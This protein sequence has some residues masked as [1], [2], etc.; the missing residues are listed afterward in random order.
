M[1][2]DVCGGAV[3]GGLWEIFCLLQKP[4]AAATDRRQWVSSDSVKTD[5]DGYGRR[6][7]ETARGRPSSGFYV[8]CETGRTEEDECC[9]LQP[10]ISVLA[11][12][13][14]L[15]ERQSPPHSSVRLTTTCVAW[16]GREL[17]VI[18]LTTSLTAH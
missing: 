15:M 8:L 17:S 9:Q 14:R 13:L 6:Q 18:N 2:M 4:C 3:C 16:R 5:R 1:V 12:S 7:K 11:P 10:Y